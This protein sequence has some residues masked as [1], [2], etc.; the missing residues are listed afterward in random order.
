MGEI[1]KY[2]CGDQ[3]DGLWHKLAV[4][5][6]IRFSFFGHLTE[7]H[8]PASVHLIWDHLNES[9]PIEYKQ[10]WLSN[11][12]LTVLYLCTILGISVIL[13]FPGFSVPSGTPGSGDGLMVMG[14]L[15]RTGLDDL[16]LLSYRQS[17]LMIIYLFL[18]LPALRVREGQNVERE[19]LVTVN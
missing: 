11:C 2:I 13:Y 9:Q 5:L 1:I 8:V 7:Q 19:V 12:I 4:C 3:I 15:L 14:V 18:G 6:P 16:K 17:H 10:K